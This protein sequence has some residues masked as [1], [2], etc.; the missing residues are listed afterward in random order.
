MK[1]TKIG[2]FGLYSLWLVNGHEVRDSSPANQE[3]GELAI[4]ADFAL[5]PDNEIWIEDDVSLE[6]R[7]FLVANALYRLKLM[8]NGMTK[9]MAYDKALVYEKSMRL[10]FGRRASGFDLRVDRYYSFGHFTIWLVNGPEV[11]DR[12]KTDFIE[13]GNHGAYSWIP[14]DEIWIEFSMHLEEYPFVMSHE[15]V[16]D[17]LIMHANWNYEKAHHLASRVEYQMRQ[18]SLVSK[19]D[20]IPLAIEILRRTRALRG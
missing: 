1:K 18:R 14:E 13:G 16:E 6:E 3:F 4:H 7:K 8:A 11:R 20:A 10:T 17:Y 2:Q 12:Y 15:F 9:A 19:H 5:I